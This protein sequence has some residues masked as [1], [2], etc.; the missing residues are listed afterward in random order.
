MQRNLRGAP[1]AD[2]RAPI[3][4]NGILCIAQL[5][6]DICEFVREHTRNHG[7]VLVLENAG[8]AADGA[9]VWPLPHAGA[10]DLLT[11]SAAGVAERIKARGRYTRPR[12]K[13]P[14]PEGRFSGR[15]RER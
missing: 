3:H 2:L 15:E 13:S 8:A 7:W 5:N 12:R 10:S 9:Q 4:R 11:W 6:E 14:R 1:R